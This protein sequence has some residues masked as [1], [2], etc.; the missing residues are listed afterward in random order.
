MEGGLGA[1]VG[2]ENRLRGRFGLASDLGFEPWQCFHDHC[3]HS[4]AGNDELLDFMTQC[5]SWVDNI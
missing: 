2:S 1:T 3:S 4:E 5:G